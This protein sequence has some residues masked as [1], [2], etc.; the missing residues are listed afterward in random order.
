MVKTESVQAKIEVLQKEIETLEAN[1]KEFRD[2]VATNLQYIQVARG[3]I[4]AL[5]QLLN[6]NKNEEDNSDKRG[7]GQDE[8]KDS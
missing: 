3:G 5:Q 6:E 8:A 4:E 2:A 7:E 1:N